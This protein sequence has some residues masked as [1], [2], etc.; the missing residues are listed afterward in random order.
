MSESLV[1]IDT[2]L[3][4]V[5]GNSDFQF[6]FSTENGPTHVRI[7][8]DGTVRTDDDHFGL[9]ESIVECLEANIDFKL[10]AGAN[11]SGIVLRL[12]DRHCVVLIPPYGE[13]P[14]EAAA[15]IAAGWA[16]G[17]TVEVW[18]EEVLDASTFTLSAREVVASDSQ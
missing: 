14:V 7:S 11:F 8:P 16:V 17:D 2:A 18:V 15:A 13:G 9:L 5:G 10:G 4:L 3:T 1:S 6:T 12:D